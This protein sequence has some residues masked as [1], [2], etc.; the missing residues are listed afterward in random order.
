MHGYAKVA[1]YSGLVN[2]AVMTVKYFLGEASGSLALKADAIHSLADVVSSLTIFLG[3]VIADRKTKAF[4]QGL[5]KVENLVALLSSFFIFYAAY[6]IGVEALWGND[7]GQ[8]TGIPLVIAGII[9]IMAVAA[10]FSRYELKVGLAVGSPSLVAEARHVTTDLLACA[11]ILLGIIS[12][13]LGYPIDRYV[14]LLV[15]VLVARIGVEILVEAVKVLL[16]ATLDYPTLNGIRK[17]LE[18]SENVKEVLSIGGRSSGRFKFVEIS[19][20]TNLKL[21][22][23]AHKQTSQIE[24]EI[25]DQ[26]PNIDKILVHYEPEHKVFLL[27]AVPLDVSGDSRPDEKS[28]LSEHF[29]EAPYFGIIT[30]DSSDNTVL[31]KDYLKN[32]FKDLERKKGVKAAELLAEYGV[33]QVMSPVQFDGKGAGYALEAMQIEVVPNSSRTLECLI[34]YLKEGKDPGGG[35]EASLGK[36]GRFNYNEKFLEFIKAFSNIGADSRIFPKTCNTCGTVFHS[37]PEYIHDTSP[38]AHCLEE[39]GNAAEASFTMQYRN[40]HCGSTLTIAFTKEIYPLLERFWEM[41]G[42]ESKETGK[43]L[44]EVVT[45][46][47]EQCNRYVIEHDGA[48]QP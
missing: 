37:F 22:R 17:I 24:E 33:D 8:I 34:A 44:R 28:R 15:A 6:E 41:L 32:P 18:S 40:C 7:S 12:T 29:G 20:T 35:H 16:D 27:I 14:A 39:Y 47:R 1:I 43:P 42:R 48:R 36:D 19:L 13:Y 31:I 46:F 11:V 21:L 2:A 5:Y 26:Y 3:I 25:L 38:T 4:P 9:V 45:E 30:K 23:D 10:V